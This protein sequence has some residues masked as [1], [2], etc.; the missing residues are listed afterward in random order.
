MRLRLYIQS[1]LNSLSEVCTRSSIHF[2]TISEGGQLLAARKDKAQRPVTHQS[3]AH[4]YSSLEPLWDCITTSKCVHAFLQAN[5]TQPSLSQHAVSDIS[6]FYSSAVAKTTQT[7][8]KCFTVLFA[9]GSVYGAWQNCS[10][11]QNM[12]VILR[13]LESLSLFTNGTATG[14]WWY[15]FT[16]TP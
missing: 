15:Q 14:H 7:S 1:L 16:M 8:R 10:W 5:E 2:H 3:K 9:L 12:V 11:F 13:W 6:C 4:V